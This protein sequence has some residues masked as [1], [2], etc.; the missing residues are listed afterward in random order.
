MNNEALP[1]AYSQCRVIF[2]KTLSLTPEYAMVD[3]DGTIGS[4]PRSAEQAVAL[5][6]QPRKNGETTI[7]EYHHN[8]GG[9]KL[10]GNGIRIL[11][12]SDIIVVF[13]RRHQRCLSESVHSIHHD[14]DEISGGPKESGRPSIGREVH[15]TA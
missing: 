8:S 12:D 4:T 10:I 15:L 9:R 1:I 11:A 5:A 14:D 2:F 13:V 6:E 3:S 7:H